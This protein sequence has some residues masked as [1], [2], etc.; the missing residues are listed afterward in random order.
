MM[1]YVFALILVK[2]DLMV[3]TTSLHFLKKVYPLQFWGVLDH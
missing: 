2:V 1:I 3:E